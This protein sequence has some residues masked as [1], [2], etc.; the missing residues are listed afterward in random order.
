MRGAYAMSWPSAR[1]PSLRYL[2]V[3]VM[4]RHNRGEHAIAG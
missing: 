2:N 1:D 4:P 3:R